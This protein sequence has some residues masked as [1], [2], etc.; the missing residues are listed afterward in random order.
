MKSKIYVF[1]IL[2]SLSACSN[3]KNY[4][5]RSDEDRALIDAVK[6]L[7]KSPSDS[8]AL[9]AVPVLYNN[10]QK[11][12]LAKIKG[13]K[14]SKD[15]NRW[16][17]LIDEYE[18]LQNAYDEI[19]NNSAAFKLV[20][21]R[22]FAAELF[23]TK[24]SAAEDYYLNG[25]A[26]LSKGGRD[27]NKKAFDYFNTSDK[28]VPGF[29][30]GLAKADQAYNNTIVNVVINPVQDNSF[31]FNSGWGNTG[32]NFSNEYFQQ[33]LVRDLSGINNKRYPA[34]FFSDWQARRDNVQPDWVVDLNL[35]NIDIPYPRNYNYTRN[36]SSRVPTGTD[37]SGN[38][39]YKTVYATVHITRSSFT[40]RA[41]MD[42]NITD[43]STGKNI[44]SRNVR[45]EYRWQE[46][47][48]TY[49][50]DSRA[51]S[52]ND[53]QLINNYG[54]GTPRKE[55]VLNELFKKIYP[56]VKNQISY[57]VDW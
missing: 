55:D 28:I 25:E 38:S 45:E 8:D 50:G 43:V 34:K 21:A 51:L 11:N 41:D 20:N 37:S 33:T 23:D 39:I 15:L 18:Y 52:G 40:S 22:S 13:L 32:Y 35:R 42:V 24:Q 46:E 53:W 36:A 6:K 26:M 56:S 12:H 31:F 17:K 3:S 30:D 14:N 44:S 5:E 16:D 27:N 10:I 29:K 1:F 48:A 49:N 2:L 19:V 54:Y 57:A 9:E 7:S 4:L 47:R